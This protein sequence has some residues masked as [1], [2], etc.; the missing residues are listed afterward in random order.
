M[1]HGLE[2]HLA[3]IFPKEV[4]QPVEEGTNAPETSAVGPAGRE[5]QMLWEVSEKRHR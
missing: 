4:P 2:E 5:S 1:E 3:D